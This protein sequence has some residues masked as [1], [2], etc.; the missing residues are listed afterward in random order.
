MLYLP[1][2][3][4]PDAGA[5][6]LSYWVHKDFA[7]DRALMFQDGLRAP[8]PS[9]TGRMIPESP[10]V[11]FFEG[12]GDRAFV[13]GPWPE[14]DPEKPTP[15]ASENTLTCVAKHGH[16]YTVDWSIKLDG[17][18]GT[19]GPRGGTIRAWIGNAKFPA[20]AYRD[21]RW[22]RGLALYS[23]KSS[24]AKIVFRTVRPDGTLG[25]GGG[26]DYPSMSKPDARGITPL[27]I[28]VDEW[29]QIVQ[30]D[31]VRFQHAEEFD[32]CAC[33]VELGRK[34]SH[35]LT[36]HGFQSIFSSPYLG[37]QSL[38]VSQK[39]ATQARSLLLRAFPSTTIGL[40]VHSLNPVGPIK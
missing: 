23:Y 14:S 27:P 35:F 38:Y 26:D 10:S 12:R 17:R 36:A 30:L 31:V 2:V 40:I 11:A 28:S 1:L 6:R 24:I 5:P 29:D 15:Y 21:L 9:Y 3:Y 13:V 22:N 32:L 20:K 33:S 34:L 18:V 19:A 39:G 4:Q 25:P 7:Y 37:Y 16:R 8:N